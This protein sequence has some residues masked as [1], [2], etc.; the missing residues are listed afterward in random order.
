[1]NPIEK[2]DTHHKE[3][4]T[5]N[6]TSTSILLGATATAA[7]LAAAGVLAVTGNADA[8]SGPTHSPNRTVLRFGV[9]FSPH[10]VVD[11]PPLAQHQGDYG[12]GDYATF[13]DVLT[14]RNGRPV[15]TEAGSGLI[16]GVSQVGAQI[17]FS[18]AIHLPDGDITAAGIG[19][20]DPDKDLV[21]TGGTGSFLG[22]QG[23]VHALEN[24]NG[25][26]SLQITLR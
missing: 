26:G 3:G 9:T 23:D 16:T 12:I 18:M 4:T 2:T 13:G 11:V 10:H 7:A 6:S 15:G 20:T 8:A 5:M 25:T 1:M 19:S 24:G 22:A 17:F 21:V 14:N